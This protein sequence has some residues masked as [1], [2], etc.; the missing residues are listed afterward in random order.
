MK[1]IIL[2]LALSLFVVS[3]DKV[4][5]ERIEDTKEK[6]VEK[7]VP[8]KKIVYSENI[9]DTFFGIK[10]G[11]SKEEVIN[12]FEKEGLDLD[13]QYS[14]NNKLTFK[15]A[16]KFFSFGGT[17]WGYVTVGLH[18]GKFYAI[19]F[20]CCIENE[21]IVLERFEFVLSE[22]SSRYNMNEVTIKDNNTH[23]AYNAVSKDKKI[24][25]II[26]DKDKSADGE[27]RPYVSLAYMDSKLYKSSDEL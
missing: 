26:C 16:G 1:K 11:A 12:A 24:V 5:K 18:N 10:F 4:K 21:E 23:K 13:N 14:T 8:K 20:E 22:L 6:T 25:V 9:Q 2:L 17:N 7:K 27:N 3:C 15:P 19:E